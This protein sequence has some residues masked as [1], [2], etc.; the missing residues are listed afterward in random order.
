MWFALVALACFG[1]AV[2]LEGSADNSAAARC[3]FDRDGAQLRD[4]S[5]LSPHQPLAGTSGP[6]CDHP[7]RRPAAHPSGAASAAA[8]KQSA[9]AARKQPA[10]AASPL[11]PAQIDLL[12][13]AGATRLL[14][15]QV[16][17]ID[18]VN[19]TGVVSPWLRVIQ[20]P[21]AS[22]RSV[23]AALLLV[24]LHGA[25]G[26]AAGTGAPSSGPAVAAAAL[27][28]GIEQLAGAAAL[29]AEG[30]VAL[31]WPLEVPTAVGALNAAAGTGQTMQ[32]LVT[33]M[34][35]VAH[36]AVLLHHE[37]LSCQ[38]PDANSCPS[39]HLTSADAAWDPVAR[40]VATAV[41]D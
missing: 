35:S 41:L 30:P 26:A 29:S 36:S 28:K 11:E 38:L 10:A 6:L 3:F 40:A 19:A 15:Q 22:Q 25:I 16:G 37:M 14:A 18:P 24:G 12:L 34:P 8:R 4:R 13:A 27:S 31:L 9:A 32:L 2:P 17:R 20:S 39:S 21:E 5:H 33:A 23:V 1:S 7:S